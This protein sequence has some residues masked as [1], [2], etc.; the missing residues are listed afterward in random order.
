MLSHHEKRVQR[1]E[2]LSSHQDTG[3]G[4]NEGLR[5]DK[6]KLRTAYDTNIEALSR[7]QTEFER[8]KVDFEKQ[9]STQR[10]Q[11]EAILKAKQAADKSVKKRQ[12]ELTA[13]QD[14]LEMQSSSAKQ[15]MNE[16]KKKESTINVLEATNAS[17][18]ETLSKA[19]K[20]SASVLTIP[21]T[22]WHSLSSADGTGKQPIYTYPTVYKENP[23]ISYDEGLFDVKRR[24][25]GWLQLPNVKDLMNSPNFLTPIYGEEIERN[26][27]IP[28]L[29]EESTY[30]NPFPPRDMQ[31]ELVAIC[32]RKY[33]EIYEDGEVQ[34]QE[35]YGILWV[36]WTDGAAY[37]KGC[38]YVSKELWE[39]QVLEDVDLTLGSDMTSCFF[40]S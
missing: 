2:N 33:P 27:A 16:I 11:N 26:W 21:V 1:V 25:C 7:H 18:K 36:E 23:E 40:C 6:V 20:E 19:E 32:I 4:E 17:Q 12:A 10:T 9:L 13:L 30:L 15:L 31:L 29:A 8:Q 39:E 14:K 38:G 35:F 24:L 22:Q 3:V 28:P 37:R 5:R 34:L